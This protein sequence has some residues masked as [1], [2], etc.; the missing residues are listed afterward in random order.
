MKWRMKEIFGGQKNRI[1][2]RLFAVYADDKLVGHIS[3]EPG[4]PT[5]EVRQKLNAIVSRILGEELNPQR[6]LKRMIQVI[7]SGK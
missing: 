7:E 5:W 1:F 3:K 4:A 6:G 2:D